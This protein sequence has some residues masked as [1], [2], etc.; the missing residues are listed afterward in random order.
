[1]TNEQYHDRKDKLPFCIMKIIFVAV[2]FIVHNNKILLFD[3]DRTN[4][5]LIEFKSTTSLVCQ[6]IFEDKSLGE[7]LTLAIFP[8]GCC[9]TA[10]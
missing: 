1:M 4:R 5:R 6:H 9:L 7:A 3:H 2:I 8:S 10:T